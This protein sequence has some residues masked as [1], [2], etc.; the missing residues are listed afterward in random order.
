[1]DRLRAAGDR[2]A[3]LE[4]SETFAA[5]ARAAVLEAGRL[6]MSWFGGDH[7]SWEKG[8]GQVVTDAD[9]AVDRFLKRTLADLAPDAG[10]LSEETADDGSRL[11][12]RRVWIVDPL[13]GT[14]SFAAAIPEFTVCVGLLE[15]GRP[16]LGFVLN[17]ATGELFEARAGQGA[18]LAG[19]P[20]AARAAAGLA[21][22][23][24]VVSRD[25]NRRR[26]FARFL[27]D[28]ELDTIGSLALK[29]C[30]VAAGRFDGY[31]SWRRAHDWDIAAA[32][33]ILEEAGALLTDPRGAT[34]RFDGVQ[35][36]RRGLV[37]AT[38]ALHAAMLEATRPAFE[39]LAVG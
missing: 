11:T 22:A 26:D 20:I 33:L 34:V 13:D 8:P 9:L 3:D 30:L 19:R 39:A 21:G 2:Q 24:I 14:R 7:G 5:A 25:E 35:P 6:A 18:T 36:V 10:W 38:P 23:R 29:L 31:L 27:P 28:A 12:A 4:V 37:A 16:V 32:A 15:A 17:P 1:M